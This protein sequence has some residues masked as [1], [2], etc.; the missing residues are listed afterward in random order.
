[1]I[2]GVVRDSVLRVASRFYVLEVS[3]AIRT[4]KNMNSYIAT[5]D[6]H[7]FRDYG[8]VIELLTKSGA[9]RLQESVW[10]VSSPATAQA[11]LDAILTALDDDD[12]LAVI[13]LPRGA[14]WE[15]T[16]ATREAAAWLS[17][18]VTPARTLA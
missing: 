2:T 14:P 11:A 8:P 17:T 16:G 5:Y 9:V 15:I 1:L 12:S 6:L 3:L 10:L 18:N 13:E 4:P 7:K